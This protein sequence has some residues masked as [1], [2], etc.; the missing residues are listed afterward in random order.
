[1]SVGGHSYVIER[2]PD[3]FKIEERGFN[4]GYKNRV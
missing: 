3:V 2:L 4:G 1:M